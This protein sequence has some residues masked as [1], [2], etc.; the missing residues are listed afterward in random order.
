M[1]SAHRNTLLN[2]TNYF[3][4]HDQDNRI[5]GGFSMLLLS[6]RVIEF[7]WSNSRRLASPDTEFD[8]A[9]D[10][11]NFV[12]LWRAIGRVRSPRSQAKS[13]LYTSRNVAFKAALSQLRISISKIGNRVFV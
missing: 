9:Q 4:C 1:N 10:S 2:I 6:H 5:R 12:S 11:G 13:D 7:R 3:V 8:W